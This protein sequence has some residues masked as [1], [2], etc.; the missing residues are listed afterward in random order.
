MSEDAIPGAF[1]FVQH[2]QIDLFESRM[3][4]ERFLDQLE[5]HDLPKEVC[6]LEFDR[7][8]TDD[9]LRDRFTNLIGTH[10]DWLSQRGFTLQFAVSSLDTV[11]RAEVE[12][13][14]NYYPLEDL[15]DGNIREQERGT[16]AFVK[17]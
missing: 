4:I 12:I 6:V 5:D 14:G 3:K 2:Q 9:D 16:W 10:Q 7:V 1:N 11:G 15:F 8:F 17:I 13:D